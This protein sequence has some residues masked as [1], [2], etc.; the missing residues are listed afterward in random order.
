M[1]KFTLLILVLV[2]IGAAKAQSQDLEPGT[3]ECNSERARINVRKM[4]N[5]YL[6][7]YKTLF[8]DTYC[9]TRVRAPFDENLPA[10]YEVTCDGGI[11]T[12]NLDPID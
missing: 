4:E 8:A 3:Y 7:T 11:K 9:H 5:H 1:K 2:T 10:Q 6:F 12:T